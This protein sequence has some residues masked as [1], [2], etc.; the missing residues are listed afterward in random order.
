[1]R[2][3]LMSILSVTM[4]C[5]LFGCIQM[6]MQTELKDDGSGT[7]QMTF[8]MSANVV[9]TLEELEE[10]GTSDSEMP[11]LSGFEEAELRKKCKEHDVTLK[12]FE[13][14]DDE[15]GKR[16]NVEMEFKDLEAFSSVM[17]E[18]SQGMQLFRTGDGN[19]LLKAVESEEEA[20]LEEEM[21]VSSAE[22]EEPQEMDMEAMGKSME[23]MGKLMA[24]IDELDLVMKLTV[25]GDIL[26][27]NGTIEGRTAVWRING[28]NMMSMSMAG[29]PEVLFSGKG[30]DLKADS[31][32]E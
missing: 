27:T 21:E 12:K 18:S 3:L 13:E 16:V 1:M 31:L 4:A 2:H 30:L 6:E 15:D 22:G 17:G 14:V 28:E 9:E 24:S 19:Y 23:L 5:F 20:D 29:E 8:G 25:P 11:S 10:L 7:F 26:E 32:E